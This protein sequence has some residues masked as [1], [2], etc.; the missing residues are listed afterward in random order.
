M[1]AASHARDASW[2]EARASVRD[3][4][5]L[6]R[7]RL[8]MEQGQAAGAIRSEVEEMRCVWTHALLAPCAARPRPPRPRD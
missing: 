2:E 5:Q 3:E 7:R 8:E 1:A 4:L 6:E